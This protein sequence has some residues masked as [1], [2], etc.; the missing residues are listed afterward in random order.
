[1]TTTDQSVYPPGWYT[2]QPAGVYHYNP[3]EPLTA[4]SQLEYAQRLM[5]NAH[6]VIRHAKTLM[7]DGIHQNVR[8]LKLDFALDDLK[9]SAGQMVEV[10]NELKD[11]EIT[12]EH[13][14][15]RQP[16]QPDEGVGFA[17]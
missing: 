8:N 2:E 12:D 11:E 17:A 1:M 7:P 16:H 15:S 4:I 5:D 10:L 14:G 13:H 9:E 6:S 3:P